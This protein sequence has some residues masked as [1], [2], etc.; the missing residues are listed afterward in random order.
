M[1]TLTELTIELA[2]QAQGLEIEWRLMNLSLPGRHA[3]Q[4][5]PGRVCLIA[6]STERAQSGTHE[7]ATG[8]RK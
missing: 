3:V 4:G 7:T 1:T 5:D 8:G 2:A 6:P